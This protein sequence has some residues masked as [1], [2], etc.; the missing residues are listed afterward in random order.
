[1]T[2]DSMMTFPSQGHGHVD[3][4]L[5]DSEVSEGRLG[6]GP[7]KGGPGMAGARLEQP[8]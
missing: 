3:L 8:H 4:L 7:S 1:M 5:T 6:R 2:H